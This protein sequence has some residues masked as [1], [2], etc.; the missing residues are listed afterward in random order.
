M[1]GIFHRFRSTQP[2]CFF[3]FGVQGGVGGNYNQEGS[4]H[5]L[6]LT[7]QPDFNRHKLM[8]SDGGLLYVL[9]HTLQFVVQAFLVPC[10]C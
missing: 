10:E 3:S 5:A 4:T 7:P 1:Y 6:T 9:C 8:V 2:T